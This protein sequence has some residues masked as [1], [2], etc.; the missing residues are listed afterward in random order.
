[1]SVFMLEK[2][3]NRCW[4]AIGA[5]GD[6]QPLMERLL[7]A[8]NEAHR[9]YHTQQHLA[10]CIALLNDHL[11]LA[12]KPAEVEMATWFHDAVY[13]VRAGDNE[14][15]SAAWAARELQQAF[16]APE[17]IASVKDHILATRHS[18]PP[19]GQDQ[20]LLVD[21]DLSILGSDR[22][23]FQA[24]ER[25]VREEYGW[26]PGYIFNR[27]RRKVLSA[28]LARNCIYNTAVLR[29]ALESQARSNLAYALRQLGLEGHAI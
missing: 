11:A 22:Q 3:W 27:K 1:M 17:R 12:D 5:A 13:N 10:E 6:G 7:G 15:R 9:K 21:I 20:M 28:F 19:Q 18:A 8:Y 2:S 23:R 24:Y 26:V 14:A 25:Q 4:R 16:V 29:D